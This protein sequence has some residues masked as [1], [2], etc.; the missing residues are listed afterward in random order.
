MRCVVGGWI[1]GIKLFTYRTKGGKGGGVIYDQA[2]TR[3]RDCQRRGPCFLDVLEACFA[4]F[5]Y[6]LEF[7]VRGG[8]NE[9]RCKGLIV[10]MYQ[11]IWQPT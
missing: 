5:P 11:R 2:T 7:G 3:A 1:G 4:A 9:I 8:G 6:V 10:R